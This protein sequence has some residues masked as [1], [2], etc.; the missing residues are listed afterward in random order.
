[1]NNLRTEDRSVRCLHCENTS[2]ILKDTVPV[3]SVFTLSPMLALQHPPYP[4]GTVLRPVCRELKGCQGGGAFLLGS[5]RS[6]WLLPVPVILSIK[7][8]RYRNDLS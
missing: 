8:A 6:C 1:M 7:L 5:Y 4:M 2:I 3:T